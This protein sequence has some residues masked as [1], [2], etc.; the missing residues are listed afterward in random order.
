MKVCHVIPNY[1]PFYAS[2]YEYTRCLAKNGI[3]VSVIAMGRPAEA[4]REV[5]DDVLVK[6]IKLQPRPRFSL[7]VLTRFIQ[8]ALKM[9]K[10]HDFDI[11]HVYAF[12]GCSLLPLLER[13]GRQ[14][15][16]LDFRTGNVKF[17]HPLL[18]RFL[19]RLLAIESL[20]FNGCA[21]ISKHVG[22]KLLGKTRPFHILPLGADAERFTP[23]Q[24][25]SLRR[26]LNIEENRMVA[27][28]S[29]SLEPGRSIETVM[30]GFAKARQK[31]PELFLLMAGDGSSRT[32]LGG[33]AKKLGV[34]TDVC[35]TGPVPFPDIH[36]FVKVGDIGLA[37]VPISTQFDQQP[38][39]KTM[40]FLSCGLPTI[41]T[42]TRGNMQIIK[43]EINGLLVE[44][45]AEAVANGLLR[46]AEN[47]ELRE[48][49]AGNS[50][51]SV[52]EYDWKLMVKDR[53]IP[54]YGLLLGHPYEKTSI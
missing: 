30:H 39:L 21:V 22:V 18:N 3:S 46:L 2:P 51:Q 35:F 17:S 43:D 32:S 27:V 15:W 36:H 47:R 54:L 9:V 13:S 53:L 37:Y 10:S 50:R 31:H 6:R 19:N 1:Y 12:R 5:I 29:G 11:I 33:L 7:P 24:N 48:T 44:D 34:N 14:R 52:A 38:V 23:G 4:G 16:V 45:S 28:Y 25:I 40:E 26:E 41:A 49:I 8:F 42:R 20:A